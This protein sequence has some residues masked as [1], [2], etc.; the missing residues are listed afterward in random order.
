MGHGADP[1]GLP[2]LFERGRGTRLVVLGLPTG[3][4]HG[5]YVRGENGMRSYCDAAAIC[6]ASKGGPS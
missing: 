4:A 5:L 6:R 1:W 2:T 3:C